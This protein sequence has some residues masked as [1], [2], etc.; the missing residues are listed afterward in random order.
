MTMS[1]SNTSAA[2]APVREAKSTGESIAHARWF[3]WLARAGLVAR[4]AIYAIIGVL[5]LQVAFGSGG[6]T[7]NQKGALA[8]ISQQSGGKILLVLMAIGLFGYAFWRLLRAAVGHGPEESDDGKERLKGMASGLAYTSLFITCLTI[9]FG[10]S[11]SGGSG[12]PDKATGGVL[13][14]PG[15]QVIVSIAG[16]VL[17]GVGLYQGYEG[18]RTKFLEKSKTE[19]MSEKTE[20]VFTTLGMAGHLARMVIFALI[21][22]FLIKAAIDFNPDKA[23]SVD[24]ALAALAKPSYGPVLLGVV[25]AGMIAFA[26]YSVADARYR[27][28]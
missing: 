4:G 23:V 26:A 3:E 1:R 27:R 7:T 8:E 25:A 21:G 16:L 13:A 14:W 20:K 9:L 6:K 2:R 18:V 28:V 11:S 5:A 15:G 22:Y 17:I 24:G 10:S 19:E 12:S